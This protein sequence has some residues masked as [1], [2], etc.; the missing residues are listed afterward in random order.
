MTFSCYDIFHI[1]KVQ[2]QKKERGYKKCQKN[3]PFEEDGAAGG[4]GPTPNGKCHFVFPICGEYIPDAHKTHACHLSKYCMLGTTFKI[5]NISMFGEKR[6]PLAETT[7]L[8]FV[9]HVK[10]RL[11]LFLLGAIAR[12]WCGK[13]TWLTFHMYQSKNFVHQYFEVFLSKAQYLKVSA[14]ILLLTPL[15]A[16]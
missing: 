1:Y 10:E 15:E 8:I 11:D 13:V 12:A 16:T 4:T 3:V 2:L 9:D 7:A 6:Y 14:K 5:L